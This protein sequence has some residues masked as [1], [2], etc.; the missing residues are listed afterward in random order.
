MA[1]FPDDNN[2]SSKHLKL[3]SAWY[4]PLLIS[5]VTIKCQVL[6]CSLVWYFLHTGSEGYIL[7]P[8]QR[9]TWCWSNVFLILFLMMTIY[10]YRHCIS[11]AH[12]HPQQSRAVSPDMSQHL[13][14]KKFICLW[15]VKCSLVLILLPV[16]TDTS[17][18]QRLCE[19]VCV[20]VSPGQIL[21]MA[22]AMFSKADRASEE[23]KAWMASRALLPW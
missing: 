22:E 10:G 7:E 4:V 20:C 3:R 8:T 16:Q 9:M 5:K 12:C 13:A 18:I 17:S 11:D 23:G 1:H 21:V 15:N 2:N 14:H 19:Y 6:K